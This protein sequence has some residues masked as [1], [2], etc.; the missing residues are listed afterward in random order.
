MMID[1]VWITTG[2]FMLRL[3]PVKINCAT[4]VAMFSAFDGDLIKRIEH[5]YTMSTKKDNLNPRNLTFALI[6]K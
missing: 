6:Y 3:S 5:L 1:M 2:V 4:Y